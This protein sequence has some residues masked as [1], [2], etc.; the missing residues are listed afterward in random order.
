M[1]DF[2]WDSAGWSDWNNPGTDYDTG[3]DFDWGSVDNFDYGYDSGGGYDAGSWGSDPWWSGSGGG[4]YNTGTIDWGSQGWSDWSVPSTGFT[5]GQGSDVYSGGGGYTAGQGSF[6]PGAGMGD[7]NGLDFGTAPA[8]GNSGVTGAM[9]VDNSEER[10]RPMLSGY[11]PGGYDASQEAKNNGGFNANYSAGLGETLSGGLKAANSGLKSVREFGRENA[12][13]ARLGIGLAGVYAA[14]K[15]QKRQDELMRQTQADRERERQMKEDLYKQ[16]L[17]AM[18]RA[19]GHAGAAFNSQSSAVRRNNQQADYWNNQATQSANEARSLYNPQELGVRGYA[20]EAA[21]TGR[22]VQDIRNK[23]ARQGK[24]QS[25]IDA[26]VRRAKVAGSTNA[27]TGFMKGLDTGRSAQTGA[28]SAAK[29]LSSS[30]SALASP[31]IPSVSVPNFGS[32][33]DLA[34]Y[35][36]DQASANS[37]AIQDLLNYYLGNPLGQSN[38]N[39]LKS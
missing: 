34:A 9:G 14:R 24:S 23:M 13:L 25:S 5:T 12:D 29:G 21:S 38:D 30:Y 4:G 18:Q 8:A 33:S 31:S 32:N 10:D 3:A 37:N 1:D 6:A 16:Q 39:H 11:A 28:L 27:T 7:V 36:G 2:D 20:Q 26:E 17:A 35:Y 15:D 22:T 19:S